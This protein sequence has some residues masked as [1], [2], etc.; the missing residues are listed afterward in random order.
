V[1]AGLLRSVKINFKLALDVVFAKIS[2]ADL[3]LSPVISDLSSCS[4]GLGLVDRCPLVA[5]AHLLVDNEEAE[6]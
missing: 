6:T 5:N 1:F 2:G 3:D 4:L